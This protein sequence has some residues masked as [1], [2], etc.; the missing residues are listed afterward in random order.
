MTTTAPQAL[1]F[2]NDAFVHGR[3]A[4]LAERII[5]EAPRDVIGTLYQ[6]VL[7]RKPTNAERLAMAKICRDS[8][9]KEELIRCCRIML[10]LNEVIYVD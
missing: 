4:A 7:Q 10:N 8:S 1:M 5:R 9:R 6:H 3:A 2:L